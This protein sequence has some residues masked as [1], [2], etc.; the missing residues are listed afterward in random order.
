MKTS[1]LLWISDDQ[2]FNCAYWDKKGR[3]GGTCLA[4]ER[5][6]VDQNWPLR[7]KL[8]VIGPQTRLCVRLAI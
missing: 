5:D 1:Y 8:I 3:P 4:W 7:P 2:W 6:R